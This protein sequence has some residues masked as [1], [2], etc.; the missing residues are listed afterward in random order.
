MAFNFWAKVPK[1][2]NHEIIQF[3]QTN[4][5][6][7]ILKSNGKICHRNDNLL[8]N[9]GVNF[10]A[11]VPKNRSPEIIQFD[12]TNCKLNIL[13]SNGKICH[14]NDNLLLNN[15]VNFWAKVPKNRSPEIIQFDQT[16]CKLNI[17]KSNGKFATFSSV[18]MDHPVAKGK[19]TCRNY[20]LLLNN[21]LNFGGKNPMESKINL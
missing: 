12:Q 18:M 5:K 10:W 2:R 19:R 20:N 8:L 17:L 15:G 9:N 6:L 3:D 4:Y 14:R 11:K 21:G 1:N 7:N 16:N 13:K